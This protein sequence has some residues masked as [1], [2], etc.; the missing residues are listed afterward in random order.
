MVPLNRLQPGERGARAIER[1]DSAA[2]A[3][4]TNEKSLALDEAVMLG[5]MVWAE[6]KLGGSTRGSYLWS[7]LITE[8]QVFPVSSARK[9]IQY[10]LLQSSVVHQD[11][12]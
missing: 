11:H 8:F 9:E 2:F 3:L 12:V 7:N 5:Q 4:T 10:D 6:D 1:V